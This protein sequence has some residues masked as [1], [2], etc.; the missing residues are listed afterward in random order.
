LGS[1]L[2]RSSADPFCDRRQFFL[3]K[4]FVSGHGRSLEK[5]PR[6]SYFILAVCSLS[7]Y[8]QVV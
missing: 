1:V 8:S 3:G 2:T 4:H 7:D 6:T 5:Y